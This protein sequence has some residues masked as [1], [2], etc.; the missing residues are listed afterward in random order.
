[1]KFSATKLDV[2]TLIAVCVVPLVNGCGVVGGP[3][4]N[5]HE[6]TFANDT[7][8]TVVL[9]TSAC[10]DAAFC[11]GR[12]LSPG[13]SYTDLMLIPI[14]DR[15]GHLAGSL[16]VQATDEAGAVVFC[17]VYSYDQLRDAE[18]TA[19]IDNGHPSCTQ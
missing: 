13:A 8:Q 12:R 10:R 16:R 15:V 4:D 1:M 19:R 6:I 2:V 18:W 7:G 5:G 17:R 3:G 11:G 9:L 14:P